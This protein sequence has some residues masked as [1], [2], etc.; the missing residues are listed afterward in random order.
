M[1]ILVFFA[2]QYFREIYFICS[3]VRSYKQC[4]LGVNNLVWAK[5]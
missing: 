5:K 3:T 1:K 4:K 2:E